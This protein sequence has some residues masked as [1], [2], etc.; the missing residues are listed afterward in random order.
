[1]DVPEPRESTTEKL[2]VIDGTA[3]LETSPEVQRV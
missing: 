1:V 3:V 2:P